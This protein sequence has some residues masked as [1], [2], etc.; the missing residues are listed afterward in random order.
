MRFPKKAIHLEEVFPSLCPLSIRESCQGMACRTIPLAIAPAD[1]EGRVLGQ[2]QDLA[3][4]VPATEALEREQDSLANSYMLT[5]GETALGPDMLR[6][7]NP[8]TRRKQEKKDTK[9]R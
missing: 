3:M 7:R 2:G 1:G 4:E 8:P 6:I 9:V 5:R